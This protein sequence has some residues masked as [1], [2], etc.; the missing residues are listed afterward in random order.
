MFLDDDDAEREPHVLVSTFQVIEQKRGTSTSTSARTTSYHRC[1]HQRRILCDLSG[2]EAT[3]RVDRTLVVVAMLLSSL[4]EL[5]AHIGCV[6]I[7][8][9]G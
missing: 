9:F 8:G 7:H 2:G 6:Y 4:H 5:V 3:I 1:V